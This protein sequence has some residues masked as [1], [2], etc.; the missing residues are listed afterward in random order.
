MDTSD[1][2]LDDFDVNLL[3]QYVTRETPPGGEI[4]VGGGGR[5][6]DTPSPP[7]MTSPRPL[8]GVG[9]GSSSSPAAVSGGP[10]IGVGTNPPPAVAGPSRPT[11]GYK[12]HPDE[13]RRRVSG[14]N[15]SRVQRLRPLAVIVEAEDGAVE[16]VVEVLVTEA[17]AVGAVE[18]EATIPHHPLRAVQVRP[19]GVEVDVEGIVF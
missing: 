16:V 12:S 5:S 9:T 8:I 3:S 19:D 10:T 7:P 1:S 14:P 13:P 2:W 11:V 17:V 4:G 6:F 15:V 18:E